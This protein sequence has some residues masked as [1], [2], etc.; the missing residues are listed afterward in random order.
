MEQSD[1][2][3]SEKYRSQLTSALVHAKDFGIYL[4]STKKPLL[5]FQQRS[6]VTCEEATAIILRRDAGG[7]AGPWLMVSL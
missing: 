7:C 2:V 1:Q 5:D 3:N 6:D 4:E